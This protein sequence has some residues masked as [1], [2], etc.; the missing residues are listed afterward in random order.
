MM[1]MY[2]ADDYQRLEGAV[3]V[4]ARHVEYPGK[5]GLVKTC[6]DEVEGRCLS[7]RLTYRQRDRLIALLLGRDA[8]P[9]E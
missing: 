4:V 1:A 7:G 8:P 3:S 9:A 5:Q 2:I 6:M